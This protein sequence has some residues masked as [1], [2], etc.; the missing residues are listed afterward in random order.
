MVDT[1]PAD[2]ENPGHAGNGSCSVCRDLLAHM[3]RFL[4]MIQAARYIPDPDWLTVDDIASELKVSKSIVYRLIR[5]GQIE[6][7]NIAANADKSAQ[8]AHYRVE[9]SSLDQYLKLKKVQAAPHIPYHSPRSQR[10]PE[11]KNYLGL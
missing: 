3:Q 4:D 1:M 5:S 8:K 2:Q 10:V 11:L 9:R 6:A 7:V